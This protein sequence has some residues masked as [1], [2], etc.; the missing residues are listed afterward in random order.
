MLQGEKYLFFRAVKNGANPAGGLCLSTDYA[1][2]R[3]LRPAR[4]VY[5]AYF[6]ASPR[7]LH[8]TRI[9]NQRTL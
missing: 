8:I 5:A 2:F 7:T 4:F 1:D 9:H 6:R 3:R